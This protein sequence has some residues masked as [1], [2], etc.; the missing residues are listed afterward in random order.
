MK[1]AN[2]LSYLKAKYPN[3]QKEEI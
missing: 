2:N 3:I 1:H